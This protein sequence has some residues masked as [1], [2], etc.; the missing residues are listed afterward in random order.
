MRSHNCPNSR[1][2][3]APRQHDRREVKGTETDDRSSQELK[4]PLSIHPEPA[5][6]LKENLLKANFDSVQPTLNFYSMNR[7]FFVFAVRR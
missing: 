3:R 7:Q 4:R 2:G 6:P 1:S 5:R